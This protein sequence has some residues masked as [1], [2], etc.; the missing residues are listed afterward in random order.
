MGV[1]ILISDGNTHQK[2]KRYLQTF[3]KI[4]NEFQ[5][6]DIKGSDS[7]MLLEPLRY[8]YVEYIKKHCKL[9]LFLKYIVILV[10]EELIEGPVCI[11]SINP[12]PPSLSQPIRKFDF[13]KCKNTNLKITASELQ[14]KNPQ[15]FHLKLCQT[16]TDSQD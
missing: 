16:K 2:F 11:L 9:F 6:S 1:S 13:L 10:H 12:P 14:T 3:I 7:K 5:V 8:N 15:N 4:F